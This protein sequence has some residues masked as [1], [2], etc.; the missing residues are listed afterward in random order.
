MW[1]GTCDGPGI[2]FDLSK[3]DGSC[4]IFPRRWHSVPGAM[5]FSFRASHPMNRRLFH[6]RMA[7]LLLELD[8]N[9]ARAEMAGGGPL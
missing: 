2:T 4:E 1:S 8:T 9:E 3:S 7:D 6:I 5:L